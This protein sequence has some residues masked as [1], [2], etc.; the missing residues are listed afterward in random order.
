MKRVTGL[1][2]VF[3]KSTN[4][5]KLKEWY[6]KHLG[7]PLVQEE[8]GSYVIFDWQKQVKL[9]KNGYTLWG[10][11]KEETKYF[12]PSN[13]S[14]MFNFT[15]DNLE[16][17]LKILQKEGIQLIDKIEENEQGKFGWILDPE[18]NKIELWEPAKK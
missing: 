14:F 8:T 9:E 2:G 12:E 15:V 6:I 1:G 16:E 18:G 5:E 3:F 17:L 13:K 7:V 4:P 10:P 11:F